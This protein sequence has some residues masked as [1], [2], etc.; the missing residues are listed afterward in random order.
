ME[1]A[2]GYAR[3]PTWLPPL[4]RRALVL[5]DPPYEAQEGEYPLI[6]A[7]LREGLERMPQAMFAI[8]YPIK[9]RATLQPLMRKLA[10]L[11]MK[12]ALAIELLVR[13]DDSPL[14]M[15][16]SGLLVLNAPW[17][18]DQSLTP[19]LRDEAFIDTPSFGSSTMTDA[20]SALIG[21]IGTNPA[22][23]YL[24]TNDN[25]P[26]VVKTNGIEALRIGAGAGG[27][28]AGVRSLGKAWM[29]SSVSSRP[30]A[31][32]RPPPCPR[33]GRP[34]SQYSGA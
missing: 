13:P 22:N 25:Q 12:S 9:Q 10:N 8:W 32:P 4:E 20:Y 11:P 15:N 30:M 29:S 27:V 33:R 31:G 24:G 14:R 3:L 2:D 21:N 28:D 6:V 18:L 34:A 23:N 5:I 26:L 17:K 7:A 16:G 1:C 19:A